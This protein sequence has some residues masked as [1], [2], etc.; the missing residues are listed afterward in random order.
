MSAVSSGVAKESLLL[1]LSF[2]FHA[3]ARFF[4]RTH[5]T[6][7]ELQQSKTSVSNFFSKGTKLYVHHFLENVRFIN[8]RKFL[9]TYRTYLRFSEFGLL[10]NTVILPTTWGCPNLLILVPKYLYGTL[11]IPI[12][13]QLSSC[14]QLVKFDHFMIFVSP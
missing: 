5:Q 6:K 13:F 1:L 7:A 12:K 2:V 9:E 3:L 4:N 14:S 10:Q 11:S 8:S